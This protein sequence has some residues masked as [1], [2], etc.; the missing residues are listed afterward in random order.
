MLPKDHVHYDEADLPGV[1]DFVERNFREDQIATQVSGLWLAQQ[2]DYIKSQTYDRLR[3][4]MNADRLV[5]DDTSTPE[6]AETITI[7][8]F[9]MVGMAKVIANYADDLPRADIAGAALSVQVK[10]LGDSYGYNVN[11]LR[12]S[13][14]TGVGLDTRKADAARRAM[15]LKIASIKLKGD[16]DFNLF[17][18][19]THPNVPEYVFPHPGDWTALTGD[20]IYENLVGL[21]S[22]YTQQNL[23]IHIANFLELATKAYIAATSKFVTGPGGLPIAALSLFVANFPGITVEH[24]WEC[25][26]AGQGANAGKDVAL[27]YERDIGNL[28]HEYVMPFSQLPPDA[29]NLEI[30]T[31]CLARSAG[32]Q[33]YYPLSLLKGYT[34]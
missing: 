26:N 34:T 18:L 8:M 1:M 22:A 28:A 16:P 3:P 5:P 31:D 33:I 20:Q 2:L 27:L 32:V 10:T 21:A 9:D 14:A 19:F 4:G 11:E 24:I 17:G 23:G 15:D 30:V 7:R 13:R 6:W 29:R 12:A 25:T